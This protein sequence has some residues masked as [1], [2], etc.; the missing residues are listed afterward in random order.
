MNA[1]ISVFTCLRSFSKY[2]HNFAKKITYINIQVP[3]IRVTIHIWLEARAYNIL[4]QEI[5]NKTPPEY[6]YNLK[7]I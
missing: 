4:Y 7:S 3:I 1:A 5:G 2:I 6:F